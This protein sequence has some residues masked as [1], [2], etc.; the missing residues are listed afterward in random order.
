MVGLW[1]PNEPAS[2][3]EV[4]SRDKFPKSDYRGIDSDFA[5]IK[6]EFLNKKWIRFIDFFYS[7]VWSSPE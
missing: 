6:D 1:K 3:I 2:E 4:K 7:R 5:W